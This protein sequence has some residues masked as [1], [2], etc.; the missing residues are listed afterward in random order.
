MTNPRLKIALFVVFAGVCALAYQ[1]YSLDDSLQKRL[2]QGWFLPPVE[3]YSSGQHFLIGSE[4]P[5][6]RVKE[7]LIARNLRARSALEPILAGDFAVL[8]ANACQALV[9]QPVDPKVKSC[10][11]VRAKEKD[12]AVLGLDETSRALQMWKGPSFAPTGSLS[13][14]PILMAQFYEGQP[15]FKEPTALPEVPL[16]C[17]QAV[18]AIEDA[19]FLHHK[20]VSVGGILRA[21]YRNVTAGHWAEGGSTITQ[22]LVKNYFLTPK[23]TIRRKITEQILAV[24]LEAR[25]SKDTI[26]EQYLNV[27]FMGLAGPYQIRGFASASRY[28]FGK[29][30]SKLNLP[31]CATLAALIN[32]PGRYNPFEHPDRMLKRRE[33]V[34]QKMTNLDLISQTE[35]AAAK[36]APLPTAAGLDTTSPAPYFLQA[37]QQE[38]SNLNLGVEHGMRVYTALHSEFQDAANRAVHDRVKDYEKT[39]KKPKQLLQIALLSIELSSHHVTALV[40]GRSYQQTQFNRAIDA[41]RQVGSEMKPFVYLTAMETLNPLSEREDTP[42]TYKSGK[43]VWT[44]KNYDNKFR[45]TIPLFIGLAESLNVPAARTGVEVGIDKIVANLKLAGVTKDIPINPSLALGAFELSPWELAQAYS[46]LGNFGVYQPI[47]T[48]ERIESLDGE[49]IWEESKLPLEPRLNPVHSA[50][51]LGMMKTTP[52]LGTAQG[53]KFYN[54]P[55]AIAAKTGTTNDQKDAWFVGLT[56]EQL[57]V[58]WVG[59]DDNA[60]TGTG[61]QMALPVWG[62]FQ[63]AIAPLLPHGDFLWPE[64]SEV[65]EFSFNNLANKFGY[66]TKFQDPPDKLQLVF[67]KKQH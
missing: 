40:G 50:E 51:V 48:I 26:L 30:V 21:I 33:L 44:P 54:I 56:P 23:K 4:I 67:D 11:V 15:I 19:D 35:M 31:E 20:G 16:V 28:Y 25:T 32:S 66:L 38:L 27:L 3:F 34:L 64:G 45:G 47:H 10:L 58:V 65:R 36:D 7:N 14:N 57:T 17:L 62:S 6:D 18:T 22:Q 39:N 2:A 13:M 24:L 42:Y 1:V 52:I 37:A 59:F 55:Q 53:L 8:E 46:T 9:H 60:P 5:V 49:P 29:N 63:Q 12:W 41:F 61:A 43:L